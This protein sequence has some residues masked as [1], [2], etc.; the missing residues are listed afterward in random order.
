[1]LAK[2]TADD[3]EASALLEHAEATHRSQRNHLG[4]AQVLCIRARR[5]RTFRARDEI[6]ALRRAVPVLANCEVTRRVIKEFAAWIA[7]DPGDAP[8][9]YWG[10]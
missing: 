9:D 10:L 5:L 2:L 4:L 8:I 3:E 1:M 6:E 7:P